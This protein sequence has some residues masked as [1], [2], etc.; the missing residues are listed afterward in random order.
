[1][2]GFAWLKPGDRGA[3]LFAFG[4]AGGDVSELAPLAERL[5]DA[6]AVACLDLSNLGCGTSVEQIAARAQALMLQLQ[7][8]G[9]YHLLGYSFGGLVAQEVA[10]RL[11]A[12][13]S[14]VAVLLLVEAVYARRFW[15]RGVWVASRARRAWHHLRRLRRATR[16]GRLLGRGAA[17]PPGAGAAPAAAV[18]AAAPRGGA[19]ACFAAMACFRPRR[20]PGLA[21]FFTADQDTFGCDPAR[22][23]RRLVEDLQVE[24]IPADHLGI[25]RRPEAVARLAARVDA[26][27]AA[28][29]APR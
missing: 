23:W 7:P 24:T 27:L 12:E 13:G 11:R 20:Y 10:R 21:I 4:G 6:R 25:V 3:P 18:A 14:P 19:A 29:R 15:P 2:P 1:M 26:R 8:E 9:P 16:G 17:R 5:S 22:L 28:G